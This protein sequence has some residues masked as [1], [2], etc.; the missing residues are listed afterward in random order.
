[1]G[2][3]WSLKVIKN[4]LNKDSKNCPIQ[5][6]HHKYC[7][8]ASETFCCKLLKVVW[9]KKT[10]LQ[11]WHSF[12]K[13]WWVSLKMTKT[14]QLLWSSCYKS[15]KHCQECGNYVSFLELP[16]LS[17]HNKR[18]FFSK[19]SHPILVYNIGLQD[20]YKK[21]S[22]DTKNSCLMQE[23]KIS[24]KAHNQYQCL[25]HCSFLIENNVVQ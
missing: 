13:V 25:I 3:W 2:I 8:Y 16:L 24:H 9:P 11:K 23:T 14:M 22:L 4:I 21:F 20:I 6:I 5:R 17:I 15:W 19:A 1:M 10:L 12:Q 18:K 7:K